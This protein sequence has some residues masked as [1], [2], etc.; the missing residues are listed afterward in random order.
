MKQLGEETGNFMDTISAIKLLEQYISAEEAES[1][2]QKAEVILADWK[3]NKEEE[4]KIL[5]KSIDSL[6]T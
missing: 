6:L 2:K 5:M 4:K 3:S 1:E